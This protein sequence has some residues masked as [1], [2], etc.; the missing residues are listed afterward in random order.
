MTP[1]FAIDFE[2]YYD[3]NVSIVT[4][5]SHH[6]V[7]HPDCDVYMISVVNDDFEW[8]G[9]PED[10]NWDVLRGADLIAHN[11]AFDG[12]VLKY[13][14]EKGLVPA[15]VGAGKLHCSAD[16]AAYL[17]APRNL[18]GAAEQLLGGYEEIDKSM[19]NYMK[20]RYWK[21]I[22]E[23][24]QKM[25]LD[26][27]LKDSQACWRLWKQWSD[28]W[29]ETEQ[30]A[31]RHTREMMWRGIRVDQSKLEE[32]IVHLHRLLAETR[33]Q[34]PWVAEM[35]VED[36]EADKP[37]SRAAYDRECRK[38]GLTPPASLAQTDEFAMEWL[39]ANEPA[40]PWIT[41]P[42]RLRRV[43]ALLKKLISIRE[44]IRDDGR[45]SVEL[46]YYGCEVT[47]RWSATNGVNMLNLP[48]DE[49]FGVSIRDLFVPD[50]GKVFG[51]SD[52]T[53]IEP[54]CLATIVRDD[55]LL[56]SIRKGFPIY[57]AH[58]RAT[59]GWA[60]GKLKEEDPELYRLA[61]A[62]S[63]GLGYQCGADKF[64][65]VAKTLAGIDLTL[66]EATATVRDYRASN[67][68]IV[69]LWDTMQRLLRESA[70]SDLEIDLPSG[71]VLR[72][73]DVRYVRGFGKGAGSTALPIRGDKRRFNYYG[74]R[75][76]ENII[77]GIARDIL[78]AA[79]PRIES[80]GFPV[81]L[82]IY[83]EVVCQWDPKDDIRELEQLMTVNPEW[84]PDVPLAAEAFTSAHYT[85]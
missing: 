58:A 75:V 66:E 73:F 81:A 63:I 3:K 71:R 33:S 32:R 43:N 7:R 65:M 28:K 23:D 35:G 1:T 21:D 14:Q 59:M 76:V 9:H 38:H 85:K 37:L 50:E 69:R 84:L 44:R 82:H 47:G 39:A 80:A 10:F 19:R 77:Q 64:R 29:P 61:K 42:L 56:D 41:A 2:T 34:I 36:V 30:R 55:V 53:Q 18:K 13:L 16:L 45:M 31:S 78:T 20:G 52:W 40:H 67:P 60:G 62:R 4:L 49:M 54:R 24:R 70:G 11:M 83:D 26:Y 68:K 57:E 25:M 6:Y 5:G 22:P 79:L 8:V 12:T 27:A 51:I 72:Y 17:Q 48:R 74:G 15:F 46:K